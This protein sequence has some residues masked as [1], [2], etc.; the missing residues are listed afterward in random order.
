MRTRCSGGVNSASA[1]LHV[2]RLVE[3]VEVGDDGVAAQVRRGVRVD[4]EPA[5]RL[6]VAGD[7]SARPAPTREDP[8][9]PVSPS[10]TGGS[11]PLERDPVR[12]ERDRE[13]AEVADVLAD[14]QRA[15]DVVL[16]QPG[17]GQRV[18]LVDQRLGAALELGPVVRLPPVGEVAVAVVLAALVVEAVAD[19]VPDHRADAAVVRGVV[20]VGVEER[21]LQDR[22]REHD[23]VHAAGGSRR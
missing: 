15:V 14:G 12:L 4:G 21:R 19:L 11:V 13:A 8:L 10:I 17:R 7:R 5:D 23:L 20:G 1:R 16:G 6:L 18:V 3:R 2:E 22:G 9:Q